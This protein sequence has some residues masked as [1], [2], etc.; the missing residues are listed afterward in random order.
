MPLTLNIAD[1]FGQVV[2]GLQQVS[3][4]GVDVENSLR[5]SIKTH[6]AAK[7][8]GKYLSSDVVFH[9]DTSQHPNRPAIGG[10]L[11]DADNEVWDDPGSCQAD[12]WKSLAM[13]LPAA[14][15]RSFIDGQY[16]PRDV[17]QRGDR[18]TRTNVERRT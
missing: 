13:H 15:Y 18:S 6:E 10:Q 1:D 2:D 5:R 4:D 17:R 14:L 16:P 9:L 8:G 7:S 11:T 12:I 3:V